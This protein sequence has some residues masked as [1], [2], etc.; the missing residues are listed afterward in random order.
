MT[1][2]ASTSLTESQRQ[3]LARLGQPLWHQRTSSSAASGEA[4]AADSEAATLYAYRLGEWLLL[5]SQQV[6]VPQPQW[7][8]DLQQML[9]VKLVAVSANCQ[10]DFAS[11]R[12][13]D[14]RQLDSI[15]ILTPAQK[16]IL[17]QQLQ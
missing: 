15:E 1:D 11:T 10:A 4:A 13:L 12:Q 2:L 3:L 5:S 16:A 8:A 17:W 9:E 7:L 14:L 6:P